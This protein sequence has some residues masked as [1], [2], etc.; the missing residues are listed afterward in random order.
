M[1]KFS[2]FRLAR[3]RAFSTPL[4]AA[5]RFISPAATP[6]ADAP[7][8][9]LTFDAIAAAH[10]LMARLAKPARSLPLRGEPGVGKAGWLRSKGLCFWTEGAGD[11]SRG[12]IDTAFVRFPDP[13]SAKPPID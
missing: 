3:Q 8:A 1:S 7:I 12:P 10:A 13:K 9:C 5:P 4:G 2:R 11:W 6:A